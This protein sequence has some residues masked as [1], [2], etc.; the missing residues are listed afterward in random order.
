LLHVRWS[1]RHLHIGSDQSIGIFTFIV[2]IYLILENYLYCYDDVCKHDVKWLDDQLRDVKCQFLNISCI[3]KMIFKFLSFIPVCHL[4]IVKHTGYT[5]CWIWILKISNIRV[6]IFFFSCYVKLI[7]R[8]PTT[9]TSK[10]F[11]MSRVKLWLT[12][13]KAKRQRKYARHSISKTILHLPKKN[14]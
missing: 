2:I 11:W 1:T 10:A 5:S 4:S 14:R 6:C 9:W 8:P 3:F 7:F 12:W 13:L